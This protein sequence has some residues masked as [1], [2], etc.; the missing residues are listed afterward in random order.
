MIDVIIKGR[1]TGKTIQGIEWLRQVNHGLVICPTPAMAQS[2]R[3]EY[4]DDPRLRIATYNQRAM[5]RGTSFDRIYIDECFALGD[6][7]NYITHE[8]FPILHSHVGNREPLEDRILMIGTPMGPR[9]D[10]LIRNEGSLF[11]ITV[12]KPLEESYETIPPPMAE[13]LR[14]PWNDSDWKGFLEE[15][16]KPVERLL[17]FEF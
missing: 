16:A 3:R 4:Q 8:L 13:M 9:P 12:E 10:W 7:L 2:L 14:M 6:P 15:F 17:S 11:N 1:R 5:I